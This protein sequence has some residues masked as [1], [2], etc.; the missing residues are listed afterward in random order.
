MRA[1]SFGGGAPT[2]EGTH[3]WPASAPTIGSSTAP[4]ACPQ[5]WTWRAVGSSSKAQT[6][7]GGQL[8]VNQKLRDLLNIN[9]GKKACIASK[10]LFT[11]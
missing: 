2:I 9:I 4:L 11:V 8:W 5:Y 10:A 3:H 7:M 1:C 6:S